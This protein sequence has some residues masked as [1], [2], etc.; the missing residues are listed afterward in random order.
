MQLIIGSQEVFATLTGLAAIQFLLGYW[1]KARLT[2]SIKDEKDRLM[3]EYKYEIK[4][5]EQASKVAEYF[6]YYFRLRSDSPEA[7]YRKI[8]QLTWELALWLPEDIYRHVTMAAAHNS[9]EHNIF[10]SLIAV[11]S[12]LLKN[13]G[14]LTQEEILFHA[15]GAAKHAKCGKQYVNGCDKY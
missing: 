1:F 13:P 14:N 2:A 4:A 12:L 8:N 11:R 15:P 9:E 5:R 3:E 7:D 6:S 10:S